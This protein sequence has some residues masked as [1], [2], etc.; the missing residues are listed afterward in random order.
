L[1][2]VSPLQDLKESFE[3]K[4]AAFSTADMTSG[5]GFLFIGGL[6]ARVSCITRLHDFQISHHIDG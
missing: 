2:T 5:G 3:S 4:T 1:L 6:S